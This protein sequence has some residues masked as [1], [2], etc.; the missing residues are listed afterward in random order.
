MWNRA[1]RSPV[2]ES[3]DDAKQ[4]ALAREASDAIH[5]F[6]RQTRAKSQS[7]RAGTGSHLLL[8]ARS[9][10]PAGRKRAGWR[11]FWVFL[12]L[13]KKGGLIAEKSDRSR[14]GQM[15]AIFDFGF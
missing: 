10:H 3:G 11:F 8:R 15:D 7:N 1:A 12:R 14:I 9:G 4:L 6:Y 13:I 2:I 5:A